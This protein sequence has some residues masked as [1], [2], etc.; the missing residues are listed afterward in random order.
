MNETHKDNW[1]EA[2]MAKAKQ[3]SLK[4]FVEVRTYVNVERGCHILVDDGGPTVG[5][6][7]LDVDGRIIYR[8]IADRTA[9]ALFLEW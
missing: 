8:G 3:A 2:Y 7:S 4:P 9:V 6:G 1:T 5:I